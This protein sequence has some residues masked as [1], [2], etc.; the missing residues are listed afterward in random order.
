MSNINNYCPFTCTSDIPLLIGQNIYGTIS[1]GITK[2]SIILQKSFQP[3][4]DYLEIIKIMLFLRINN[5]I[6]FVFLNLLFFLLITIIF[7]ITGYLTIYT[8]V[9][10]QVVL[11]IMITTVDATPTVFLLLQAG[12]NGRLMHQETTTGTIYNIASGKIIRTIGK[13]IRDCHIFTVKHLL[14]RKPSEPL[15]AWEYAI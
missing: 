11:L 10:M 4:L 13:Q 5:V 14:F 1:H 12:I 15:S 7:F 9:M 2:S 8:K 3:S 6:M